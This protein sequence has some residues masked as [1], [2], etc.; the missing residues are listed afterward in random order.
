MSKMYEDALKLWR[1]SKFGLS[2][3]KNHIAMDCSFYFTE[4]NCIL[5]ILS[6]V[7]NILFK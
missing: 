1:K 2:R 3:L 6:T 5:R 4:Q 7:L